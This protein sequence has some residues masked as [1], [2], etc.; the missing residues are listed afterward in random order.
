MQNQCKIN[1]NSMQIK[2]ANSMQTKKRKVANA[3]SMQI[4]C[5]FNANR[6]FTQKMKRKKIKFALNLH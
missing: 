1:A 5:K 6:L 2:N 3:K 4:Q